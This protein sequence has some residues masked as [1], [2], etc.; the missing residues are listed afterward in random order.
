M[1]ALTKVLV[2]AVV[3]ELG[4]G[5][6]LLYDPAFVSDWL[7]GLAIS[8]D[9]SLFARLF[10][11]AILA[12]CLACWPGTQ[13]LCNS[14]AFRSMLFYNATVAV[15]IAYIGV[16]V[17]SGLLLWPALIFHVAVTVLLLRSWRTERQTKLSN[18]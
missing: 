6:A 9:G 12:L 10:G 5:L 11:L 4:T 16:F 17:S 1:N 8:Q 3:A 18:N 14:V 13:A 2:L 15:Y 7:L